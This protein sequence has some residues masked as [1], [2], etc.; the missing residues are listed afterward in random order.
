MRALVLRR[1]LRRHFLKDDEQMVGIMLPSTV[2]GTVSNLTLALDRR[3]S[4]NLNFMLSRN[5][6]DQCIEQAGLRH[7]IT[8]RKLLDRLDMPQRPEHIILED[9]PALVGKRDKLAAA[10]EGMAMPVDLLVR[11]LGLNKVDPDELFTVLVHLRFDRRAEGRHAQPRK[12]RLELP[13]DG[14][15]HRHS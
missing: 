5:A 11:K 7:I 2:A 6:L 4:V 9:I 12:H 8:S 13:G 10:A 3:V 14:K 15:R 1:I